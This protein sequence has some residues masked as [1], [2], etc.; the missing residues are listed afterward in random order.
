MKTGYAN[1][2][3]WAGFLLSLA[4]FG[5]YPLLFARFP[6]TRDVPWV[7]FLLFSAAAMLLVVGLLRAFSPR[8]LY[9]GKIVGPILTV[10]SLAVMGFFVSLVFVQSRRLPSAHGAPRV[11]Q[12]APDFTLL[13]VN[14]KPVSLSGLLAEAQASSSASGKAPRSVLL[15][16]YRGYW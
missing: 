12:K 14:R 2:P 6:V 13:D 5:S 4:A 8:A 7:N 9:R 16:F 1:W 10:T 3:I 15:V 11:G